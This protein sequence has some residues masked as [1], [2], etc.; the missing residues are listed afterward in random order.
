MD[1]YNPVWG[2]GH[3]AGR[4]S[5]TTP[6]PENN[7]PKHFSPT[8][9]HGHSPPNLRPCQLSVISNGLLVAI[10]FMLNIA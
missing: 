6:P 1:T 8:I 10:L 5:C 4:F 3:S 7:Y 2:S 9:L